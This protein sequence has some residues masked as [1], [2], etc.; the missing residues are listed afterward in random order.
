MGD[1]F[2][3]VFPAVASKAIE[4]VLFPGIDVRVEGVSDSFDVLVVEA[5][6]T[7]RPG[8]CPDCRK[9]AR[10]VHSTYQRSLDERPLGHRQVI[11]RLRVRR[12][13]CDR[14]SC[15]RKTFVEQ[16]PGLS[17]RH[18]RSSTGLT[19]WLCSIAIEHSGRPAARLC[20]RLRLTAG[21]TRLLRLLTA[22]TVSDRAPRALGVDE[23]AFR[24]GCTYGT[25]LVD[26]EAGRVVDVLPDRTSETFAAW[27]TEHP[28][29]EI[30]CRDRA[31]AYTKAVKDAAPNALEVADRWHLLQNLSTAVEKTCH[32]HRDCL[33]KRAED[34]TATEVPEVTPML[35]PPAELPRT[36]IIE[37]TRHRYED[38][39]RLLE[40]RRTI[41]AIAR[42]LNLDR[43]TVRRFRDTDLD[44]LL[45]SAR[46]RRPNGV[47]EPFKAYLNARFTE[48][49]GQVSGTRLFLEIQARGYRGSRQVVCKHLAAL[50]AGTAEPVRADIPSPRKITS[51]IM[52][53][54]ETLIDRQNERLL[55]VRLACPDITRAC[56]L[57]RAFADLVR[58]QRGYLL[59]EWIRQAEQDAPKPMKGSAGFLRQ[60]LDAVT[61]GLTLPWSSGVVEGHVNRMKTL[62]RAMYGRAS[63]E[64]LRT[65][66]LTQP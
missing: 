60:D 47:L 23:F 15:S 56:D 27:L 4:D 1:R 52:R 2:S 37:R 25:V 26:V 36:Q 43:K 20:R 49:Q 39:H 38:I 16:V 19:G 59:Q 66:I 8:R 55:Q 64:L 57:A 54:R 53:P 14:R 62:K 32:Q 10:R 40:K 65:R 29:A 35:L 22:P 17:E 13:F 30:I 44:Q 34:E 46:E 33:R 21:R 12:Y 11:V 5:V 9:Q 7:A 28:G 51:W 42:R 58:H 31:S 63:F 18:R 24:K 50:C 61:S 6:S 48:A 41:S 45:A 3:R